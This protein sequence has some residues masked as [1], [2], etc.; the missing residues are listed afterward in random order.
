ME[1]IC[2]IIGT[3]KTGGAEKQ[4]YYLVKYIDRDKFK[5]AVIALRGGNME[6]D[7]RKIVKV[8]VLKKRWKFD[9]FLFFNLYREIKRERP[10]ILHTIMFTSNTW[11]R[12]CGILL[13][14]PA[15]VASERSMDLWKRWYHFKIDKILGR[16]TRKIIC[17]SEEVKNYYVN[18]TDIPEDKFV[19][20]GNGV[21]LEE[22]EKVEF[23]TEK[24]KEFNIKQDDFV[25]LTGGRLCKE[26]SIDFFLSMVPELKNKINN[27]K[28]LIV[29]EGEEKKNLYNIVEK[30]KIRDTVVFTGYRKDI[31]SIIKISDI[32]VLTSKWEGM[33][34][35]ILEGMGLKKPVISTDVGGCRELIS[36]GENGFLIKY[37][38]KRTFIEKIIFLYENP[39][40][41]RKMGENGYKRVR[42]KFDLFKKIKEYEEIYLNLL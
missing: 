39:E 15:I 18:K 10:D 3:L 4:L 33:P 35:L 6:E 38:D 24:R 22:I 19:V 41:R 12:I 29:G 25:I 8:R 21:N 31:L 32:V 14:I 30:L 26:K 17:V 27:L 9:P 36:D 13:K 23:E 20:I 1:K 42:E 28:V 7:F 5:P 11:G 16:F 2:Y 37:G 40:V 34:N